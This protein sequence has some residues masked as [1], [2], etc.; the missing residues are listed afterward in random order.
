MAIP[1]EILII[2]SLIVIYGAVIFFF[3]E[4]GEAGLYVWT[5]IATIAANIEVLILVDAF[6][7]EQTLGNVLF[8]S[9]V[10]AT[11][12]LSETKGKQIANTAV[13]IGVCTTVTFVAISQSWFLFTPNANDFATESILMVFTNT[14]RFMLVGIAVYAVAQYFDVWLY[15]SLWE[16]LKVKYNDSKRGLW[17]RNNISTLASQA[18]NTV[19]FTFGAFM[20]MYDTNVLISIVFSSYII[21]IFTSLCDTPAIYLARHIHDKQNKKNN[22]DS[23]SDTVLST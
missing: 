17:I 14:P 6:G 22:G 15:H 3:S 8:A 1:N 19:L 13:K 11:D 4:F 2:G 9:T 10:L 21:F 18:L 16:K 5:A 7:M 20:G 12:I 23:S